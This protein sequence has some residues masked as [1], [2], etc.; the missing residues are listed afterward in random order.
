MPQT[1]PAYSVAH[2]GKASRAN[3]LWGAFIISMGHLSC[4]F[5][6]AFATSQLDRLKEY[7]DISAVAAASLP[8]PMIVFGSLIQPF[9]GMY[10]DAI[11]RRRLQ[12]VLGLVCAT[13]FVSLLGMSG[14]PF[15]ALVLL[16]LGGV[17]VAWF[18]PNAAVIARNLTPDKPGFTMSMF[19]GAGV[20]GL[21]LSPFVARHFYKL[22]DW[23]SVVAVAVPGMLI[24]AAVFRFL[25]RHDRHEHKAG[26]LDGLKLLKGPLFVV[27]LFATVRALAITAPMHFMSL[28]GSE[29]EWSNVQKTVAITSLCLAMAIGNFLGMFLADRFK[30][31]S[32]LYCS[33]LLSGVLIWAAYLCS[34]NSFVALACCSGVAASLGLP[35][36]VI[37]AQKAAPRAASFASAMVMGASWGISGLLMPALAYTAQRTSMGS[38]LGA[39]GA[40]MLLSGLVVRSIRFER[41]SSA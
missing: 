36:T 6:A 18:H 21:G 3:L 13:L 25:P 40:V 16:S 31:K 19:I 17:G 32:L 1:S 8:V 7:F 39:M 23:R 33:C 2:P 41:A 10:G 29:Q 12:A 24:A 9:F 34:Y 15:Q 30:Y 27:F 5:Y 20:V 14:S 4:D 22:G 38:T 11:G 37:V 35:V 26:L 28:Y